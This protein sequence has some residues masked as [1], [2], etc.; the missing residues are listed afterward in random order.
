M[1]KHKHID[2]NFD[3]KNYTHFD[4][5]TGSQNEMKEQ[6]QP[7]QPTDSVATFEINLYNKENES[8][9]KDSVAKEVL[10]NPQK[11]PKTTKASSRIVINLTMYSKFDENNEKDPDGEKSF[12]IQ[13]IDE[14]SHSNN[15][16]QVEKSK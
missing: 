3:T 10:V 5:F 2:L 14:P 6:T 16:Y 4:N 7:V 9:K 1:L 12:V 11:A 13:E 8:C 15:P